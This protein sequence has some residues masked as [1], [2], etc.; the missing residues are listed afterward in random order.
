M[1]FRK[2][3]SVS[4]LLSLLAVLLLARNVAAGGE[5]L[6]VSVNSQVCIELWMAYRMV[7]Y[8]F[9]NCGIPSSFIASKGETTSLF[10]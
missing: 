10:M 9:E 4:D 1:K 7:Q 5:E 2:N 8:Y 3:S 6:V